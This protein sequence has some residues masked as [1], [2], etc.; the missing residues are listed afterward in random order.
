MPFSLS[1]ICRKFTNVPEENIA[2]VLKEAKELLQGA[3]CIYNKFD[4]ENYV[5]EVLFRNN[6]DDENIIATEIN[7]IFKGLPI[8]E[9]GDTLIINNFTKHEIYVSS[10]VFAVYGIKSLLSVPVFC[11]D[12]VKG[13]MVL[14]SEEFR[15]FSPN[16]VEL[17]SDLGT[18][19]LLEENHLTT[20][21]DLKLT[22]D[23]Y[24]TVFNNVNDCILLLK[25]D[26]IVD[27]N[28]RGCEMFGYTKDEILGKKTIDLSPIID[29]DDTNNAYNKAGF[30]EL[31]MSG[32]P[33]H[34]E[35]IHQKK[36]GT[37]FYTDIS[38]TRLS[39][40]KHY[41]LIAIVRDI[42]KRKEYEKGL[43]EASNLA[44]ESNRMKSV[45][46]ASM[47]HELRTPLN[48]IIGFSD[49]L[50]DEDTTEDE[51]E[52]FTKLIQTAGRSLMQLI[53]D[54]I[55]ISKIESGHVTIQKTKF[56]VNSFL[57]EVLF[58]FK[59]EKASRDKSNIELR[60]VLSD[61]TS[62]LMIETDPYRLQQVFYNLLSNSLK[63]IDDG[64]IEFGYLSITPDFIQF[65]VK[66]TGVGIDTSKKELIFEHYGQDQNIYSRNQEGTGLGL[67]I[68]KSFVEL[69]GG[70][71]WLDSEID[72][73][74]TFY[75][76]IPFDLSPDKKERYLGSTLVV[77]GIDWS[78]YT[79]V[80]A[81][82]VEENYIFLK[83]VLSG[84]G[85]KIK[86]ALNGQEAVNICKKEK[87][88]L[89]LMDIRM[90]VMDGLEA[91]ILIKEYNP[92][93]VI[94]AQTAFT[95]AD[96]KAKCL[97]SG[98]D[99]YFKKPINHERLFSVMGKYFK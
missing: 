20:S 84:T 69:L 55:D 92:K 23:Q 66:D 89:V 3:Y 8:D 70:S 28:N 37:E 2:T 94:I 10:S 99:E 40:K 46:L 9:V 29:K 16:E 35:W 72:E 31:A 54:I 42:T 73:G 75:F 90:P 59:Q 85:V 80:I 68:S 96:D 50:L 27:I 79:V 60:L 64:F 62:D 81:D 7:I 1:K 22:D 21:Q 34:F 82:D 88:D 43:V 44:N 15:E 30:V 76:T 65:Y 51:K 78:K 19:I 87:V 18:L 67:A 41:N 6:S 11:D 63:F 49:L 56:N 61:K 48:S 26:L 38:L 97:E 39:D 93:I 13:N 5:C 25:R 24:G 86:W 36:D 33:Q 14:I 12:E 74:S 32:I 47:S 91:T 98:F 71:I 45:S 57:Q 53:G 58:T 4:R 17:L 77:G 52:L 83:G 95:S